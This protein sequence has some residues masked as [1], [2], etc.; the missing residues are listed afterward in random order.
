[1]TETTVNAEVGK[2]L[3]NKIPNLTLNDLLMKHARALN[4]P[5]CHVCTETDRL[6]GLC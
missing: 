4:A 1:M 6:Y 2:I 5:N 3:D